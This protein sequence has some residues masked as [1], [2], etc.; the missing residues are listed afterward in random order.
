[1]EIAGR[2]VGN[3]I[4]RTTQTDKKVTGF[5]IAIND[6][7][8]NKEGE[9]LENTTYVECSYWI[10]EGL[11]EYITKGIVVQLYG[12]MG[13]RAYINREDVAVGVLTMNVEKIKLLSKATTADTEKTPEKKEKKE[14]AKA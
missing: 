9:K 2:V 6:S 4:V 1:M 11:A 10:N 8:K 5:T 7:Y 3:A 12:R 14:T 13:A